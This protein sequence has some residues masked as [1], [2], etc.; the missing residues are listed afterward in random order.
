MSTT[1][2]LYLGMFAAGIAGVLA[3]SPARLSARQNIDPAIRIGGNDLGGAVTSVD[4][5][6]PGVFH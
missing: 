4:G 3:A 5:P 6:E 1:R 2:V